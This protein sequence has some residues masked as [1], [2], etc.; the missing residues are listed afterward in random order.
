MLLELCLFLISIPVITVSSLLYFSPSKPTR[1]QGKERNFKSKDKTSEFPYL[2]QT[3]TIDISVVVP[4][5]NE[6]ERLQIMLTEAF[7]YLK[8]CGKTWELIVV[9]D[10]SKDG[11]TDLALDLGVKEE[12]LRVLTLRKNRGKGGAVMQVYLKAYI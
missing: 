4:A 12:R 7:E 2:L 3:S 9:D 11:T 8:A 1:I 10:G 5:Y 6:T